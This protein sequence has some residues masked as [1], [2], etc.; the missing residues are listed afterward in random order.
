MNRNRELDATFCKF[1]CGQECLEKQEIEEVVD[2]LQSLSKAGELESE[3]AILPLT[4]AMGLY[5]GC[6]VFKEWVGLDMKVNDTT[7]A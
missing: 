5:K 7:V 2:T 4:R 3:S 6:A 1:S